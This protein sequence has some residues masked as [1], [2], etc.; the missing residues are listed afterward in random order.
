VRRLDPK[1]LETVCAA[2]A[3]RT[4]RITAHDGENRYN[5][6]ERRRV[7]LGGMLELAHRPG[8]RQAAARA[9][10]C[11]GRAPALLDD[12]RLARFIEN[13]KDALTRLIDAD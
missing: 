5:A 13:H 3:S 10:Q 2:I 4:D 9:D 6:L 8:A 11:I 12:W 1:A 7:E